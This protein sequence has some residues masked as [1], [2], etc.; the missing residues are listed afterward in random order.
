MIRYPIKQKICCY[1]PEIII[2]SNTVIFNGGNPSFS[3]SKTFNGGNPSSSG[4]KVIN[5]GGTI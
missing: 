3:G 1:T 5:G 4:P 2:V